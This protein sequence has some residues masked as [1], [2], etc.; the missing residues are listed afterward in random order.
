M[1]RMAAY[2]RQDCLEKAVTLFWEKGFHATSLKDIE[3]AL[4]MRPGSIYAAFG[5][6]ESLYSQALD[7]YAGTMGKDFLD[8]LRGQQTPIEGLAEYLRELGKLRD[9]NPPS[10]ACMLVKGLLEAGAETPALQQKIETRLA[11]MEAIFRQAF[12]EAK[13]A[14]Q[15]REPDDPAHQPDRL[16][17]RLQCEVMGLRAFAQRS[18]D[19][20]EL[21]QLAGDLADTVLSLQA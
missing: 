3:H 20:Q 7:L 2:D 15:I 11:D 19:R 12:A 8:N 18:G 5:N 17:R 4:D 9:T 14:G 21:Q 6:K 16:A 13:A 1:P 10:R